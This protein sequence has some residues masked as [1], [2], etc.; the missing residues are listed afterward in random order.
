MPETLID[1]PHKFIP[2]TRIIEAMQFN[3]SHNWGILKDFTS[4]RIALQNYDSSKAFLV[5][6][7]K[8]IVVYPGDFIVKW[9]DQ[10]FYVY[11]R[12]DF[13]KLFTEA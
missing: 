12:S 13:H 7:E 8:V 1:N 11:S 2:V 6:R 5:T 3:G 4:N 9:N 10:E